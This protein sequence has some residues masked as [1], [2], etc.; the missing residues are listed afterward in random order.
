MCFTNNNNKKIIGEG[1]P[2]R[3]EC[4]SQGRHFEYFIKQ[5]GWLQLKANG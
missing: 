3:E 4:D 2:A 1:N 5:K